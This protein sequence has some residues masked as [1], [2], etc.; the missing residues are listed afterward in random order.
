VRI[1]SAHAVAIVS[2]TVQAGLRE[3][4][5]N[6]TYRP[7][8]EV[9][10]VYRVILVGFALS[11]VAGAANLFLLPH[12][13]LA[14]H[15]F[16]DP[17]LLARTNTSGTLA[18]WTSAGAVLCC[19]FAAWH[20]VRAYACYD[21][22]WGKLKSP[23]FDVSKAGLGL[24]AASILTLVAIVCLLIAYPF[25]AAGDDAVTRVAVIAVIALIFS[26]P[27][28]LHLCAFDPNHRHGYPWW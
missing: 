15:V 22:W 11:L 7:D 5:M 25:S 12:T 13:W 20:T 1:N 9:I 27:G 19:V 8:H 23:N 14:A 4:S 16:S 3:T 21:S 2:P 6:Q 28:S 18:L 10:K 24:G 17:E 26:V